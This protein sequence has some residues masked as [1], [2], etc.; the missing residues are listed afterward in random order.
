MIDDPTLRTCEIKLIR[1]DGSQYYALFEN[2][3]VADGKG[4]PAR[5]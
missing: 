3:V 5:A 1:K 2:K 4:Y